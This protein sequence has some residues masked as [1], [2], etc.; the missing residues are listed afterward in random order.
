MFYIDP[1]EGG[2]LSFNI[3]LSDSACQFSN[4]VAVIAFLASIGELELKVSVLINWIY[5]QAS[6]S[7][8]FSLTKCPVSSLGNISSQRTCHSQVISQY[9]KALVGFHT[10]DCLQVSGLWLT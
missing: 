5:F 4:V 2:D 10:K 3:C 6:L 7:A 8:S 1:E 9:Q